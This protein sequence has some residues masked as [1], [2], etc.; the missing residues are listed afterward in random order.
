VRIVF[1]SWRDLA[2]PQAGGSEYVVD[3]LASG[4]ARAGHEVALLCGGPIGRRDYRMIDTGGRYAQ[5]LRAPLEYWRHFRHCDVVIDVENGVPFFAPLWQRRP[6]V[7]LVH[8][9]HTDQ[10]DHYFPPTVSR[11][12][13]FL[14]HRVMPTFYRRSIFVAVSPSTASAL[15]DLG[16][17]S[18]H[19]RV[20]EM[21]CD[22]VPTPA[23]ES[24][25]PLFLAL[26][27][28]VPHKRIELLL[29]LWKRVQPEVGGTLAIAGDG[30]ELDRLRRR[31]APD[32]QLL[33]HVSEQRKR[34]LL[35]NAW[36]LVNSSM[37][38]GWGTAVMEAAAAGTPTLAFDVPGVRDSVVGGT[39]G[40]LAKTDDELVDTWVRLTK[41]KGERSRLAAGA[42][43]RAAQFTWDRT[44]DHFTAVIEDAVEL[45]RHDKR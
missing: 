10:W 13:R 39:S 24:P 3:R 18:D 26:G 31:G 45:H 15:A 34:Q 8:H 36:L 19:I 23:P 44:F 17:E 5:Y 6:V 33:G 1:L 22:Q 20:V 4:M 37:H 30:P 25:D 29:D 43:A 21:G 16:I 12:G 28:L 38:E 27:R 11:A 7:C 42:H 32:V 2:N 35:G 41:E 9:V 40:V 14:E